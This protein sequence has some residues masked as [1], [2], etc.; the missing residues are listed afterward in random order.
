MQVRPPGQLQPSA[1][2]LQATVLFAD[3]SGF[4]GLTRAFQDKGDRGVETFTLIISAYLGKLISAVHAWGGYVENIYGDAILAFWPAPAGE[5]DNA[6]RRALG[7]AAAIVGGLDKHE[8]A[9]GV[10]L[11]IRA[12]AVHGNLLAV[13][14][15]GVG[16]H[17]HFLLAGDCLADIPRLIR[18]ARP[19]QVA[20]SM[21]LRARVP[22][23]PA[24]AGPRAL[25]DAADLNLAE[26]GP[27][28]RPPRVLDEAVLRAFLPS[29]LR[30]RDALAQDWLAEFRFLAMLCVGL[31]D[32]ACRQAADLPMLQAAV[33]IVQ[34]EVERFGGA[35]IRVSMSDKG[36]MAMIAFGLPDFAHE[37]DPVR[38]VRAGQEIE[39]A[40]LALGVAARWTVAFGLA[41][42]GVLGNR[43][44]LVYATMGDAVNRAAKLLD[45][46]GSPSA[47]CDEATMQRVRHVLDCE[48]L[49]A[50]AKIAVPLFRPLAGIRP[51]TPMDAAI[52]GRDSDLAWLGDQLS[53]LRSH[54]EVPVV[55]IDGE[56]GIGK[57]SLIDA[58]L[59][60]SGDCLVLRGAADP[61]AGAASPFA[62]WAGVFAGV[63]PSI[64]TPGGTAESIAQET[65]VRE[66]LRRQGRPPGHAPLAAAVLPLLVRSAAAAPDLTPEDIARVTGETL[67]ALLRDRLGDG[68][69]IVIIEDVHDMDAASWALAASVARDVPGVLLVLLA[70]PQS[71][72]LAAGHMPSP[73]DALV[74][75]TPV[76][77]RR[78]QP[79]D[80]AALRVVLAGTLDCREIAPDLLGIIESRAA[81]NPLFARQL[82][83]ALREEGAIALAG[84]LAR[85]AM[86][87]GEAAPP[88]L[89]DSIQR[90]IAAR[91]DRLPPEQ[92]LALKAASVIGAGFT[93]RALA[94]C[95]AVPASG[96]AA[97]APAGSLP[98]ARAFAETAGEDA[99][100]DMGQ[101]LARL[102]GRG[103]I[104]L[105]H[106][107]R[108]PAY[109]F[110]H[111]LTQEAVYQLLTFEQ[112]RRLHMA[113]AN[114][115][116]AEPQDD[117]PLPAV[118]GVHWSRADRPDRAL[119]YWERAGITALAGG[120][121][122][123]SILAMREAI[124]A[125]GSAGPA[126]V[127]R[128]AK[129]PGA[130]ASGR[131]ANLHAVLGEALLQVGEI[132]ECVTQE[133]RALKAMGVRWS[134]RPAAFF[135]ALAGG[136]VR[137]AMQNRR[138]MRSGSIL[139]PGPAADD[140]QH[141]VRAAL[142]LETLG[143]ALGH[144]ARYERS[145][146]ATLAALNLAQRAGDRAIYSRSAGLLALYLLI[147]RM[148]GLGEKYLANARATMPD[149]TAPRDRLMTM[150]YLAMFLMLAGRLDAA[151]EELRGMIAL[152][153]AT[154]N[155]RRL[156]DAS[157]LLTLVLMERGDIEDAWQVACRFEAE[158]ARA[159]DRQLRCWAL[160]EVAELA[161]LRGE[162][163]AAEQR[164]A[165]VHACGDAG[166]NEHIWSHGVA[167]LVHLRLG[168]NAQALEEARGVA[169][170]AARRKLLPPYALRGAFGAA[171]VFV[172][173]AQDTA[174]RREA[175][176]VLRMI[177][178]LGAKYPL[179]RSRS[180]LLL[181][182]CASMG[183]NRSGAIGLAGRAVGEAA[184]IQSPAARRAAGATLAGFLHGI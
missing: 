134:D 87:L 130:I 132:D 136:V 65:W 146:V 73:L 51:R 8:A 5:W 16:G 89:P 121:Y 172:H 159:A 55:F 1:A 140:R 76:V 128:A 148:P 20:A 109:G 126:G 66:A 74:S 68:T 162:P 12:A 161:L 82:A 10:T 48:A 29:A 36:P 99:G 149:A 45:R 145:A 166:P 56:A 106:G 90:A 41:Y 79:L 141:L 151:E 70:R 112:R 177:A 47:L 144:Q 122:R 81:G 117:Q 4:S 26:L 24:L 129:L 100:Q 35:V 86:P 95:L 78:L 62:A 183:R 34:R 21:A 118:L 124:G 175:V 19:G 115:F 32:L 43:S 182:R 120:A 179:T 107:G 13:Q 111:A 135:G 15:G 176:A 17:W 168:R 6:A 69:A 46:G 178:A 31:P 127:S 11:R 139:P 85:L 143:Q 67:C 3:V 40:L 184:A 165:N 57:T 80:A 152:A 105:L 137:Q 61:F 18:A 142:A 7:C 104:T 22:R 42:C 77:R 54:R 150:E 156:L 63:P 160:L 110:D 58:F 114:F 9:E 2:P 52:A 133:T 49:P 103:L 27:P 181:A 116:E 38:A 97:S 153:T 123:E 14:T 92:Q 33:T 167:A 131:A 91:V 25:R 108:D 75:G 147:I 83:L 101:S 64:G 98:A 59:A 93:R 113:A 44:R 96:P 164:M 119:P 50:G 170:Y 158:T 37:D 174:L 138:I 171:E 84:G 180:T 169:A 23:L 102:V 72:V 88:V 157:S 173:A 163:M 155:R 125:A 28:R 71:G 53:A 30:R 94:A 39:A 154:N 60:R